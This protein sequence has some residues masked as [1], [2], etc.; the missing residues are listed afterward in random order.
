MSFKMNRNKKSFTGTPLPM[1]VNM[2][3][4]ANVRHA[5]NADVAITHAATTP[6]SN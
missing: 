6:K 2:L 1:T 4:W 3:F 5:M